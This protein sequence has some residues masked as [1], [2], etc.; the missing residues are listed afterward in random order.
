[1]I[2]DYLDGKLHA[3]EEDWPELPFARR[4]HIGCTVITLP[5]ETDIWA[6]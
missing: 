1:M 5:A 6:I 2:E 4:E 3:F